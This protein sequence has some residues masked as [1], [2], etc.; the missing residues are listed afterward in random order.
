[1]ARKTYAQMEPHILMNS[2]VSS[3]AKQ[4]IASK[5]KS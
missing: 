4:Q 5:T 1:M 2:L 3:E